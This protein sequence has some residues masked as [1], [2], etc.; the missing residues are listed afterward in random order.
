MSVTT[1]SKDDFSKG[2]TL[3]AKRSKDRNYSVAH[4]LGHPASSRSLTRSATMLS[5]QN[6]KKPI[7]EQVLKIARKM[8]DPKA[9]NL[10]YLLEDAKVLHQKL[11]ALSMEE[12]DLKKV[13]LFSNEHL[14][15]MEAS[16]KKAKE[17]SAY[18]ERLI[19]AKTLTNVSPSLR[20]SV[21]GLNSSQHTISKTLCQSTISLDSAKKSRSLKRSLINA[22]GR[23][24]SQKNTS[25][26]STKHGNKKRQSLGSVNSSGRRTTTATVISLS[27]PNSPK[28][29]HASTMNRSSSCDA[30]STDCDE[31]SN[32]DHPAAIF[33]KGPDP[34]AAILNNKGASMR[35]TQSHTSLQNDVGPLRILRGSTSPSPSPP[36]SI[37]FPIAR[38]RS[39]DVP[40]AMRSL[41]EARETTSVPTSPTRGSR[42]V[43]RSTRSQLNMERTSSAT[44]SNSP[45]PEMSFP[46]GQQKKPPATAP[47]PKYK[48]LSVSSAEH[49]STLPSPRRG[50][51]A[52][53]SLAVV[54]DSRSQSLSRGYCIPRFSRQSSDHT[55]H[56]SQE[57]TG[58]T[59]HL[60]QQQGSNNSPHKS[61]RD[62]YVS[63]QDSDC[64][65]QTS[66]DYAEHTP[67]V[68]SHTPRISH[69]GTGHTSRRPGQDSDHSPRT[70]QEG[71]NKTTGL[72]QV[73]SNRSHGT[74]QQHF[75]HSPPISEQPLN[76]T[77]PQPRI[78]ERPSDHTSPRTAQ[79]ASKVIPHTPMR[80]PWA[81]SVQQG[82]NT[83]STFNSKQSV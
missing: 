45:S 13:G 57:S 29:K 6:H 59:P 49:S 5:S 14:V 8:S 75:N 28:R 35:S 31:P 71:A 42:S 66:Q 37:S 39:A 11:M 70:S 16:A 81:G 56:S 77:P 74:S 4:M 15:A 78:S 52:T 61:Q 64:T 21:T 58:H 40:R 7:T 38:Q 30:L 80:D 9:L 68:S 65:P 1:C 55:P 46:K 2:S 73:D 53:Q 32:L 23:S 24:K 17:A 20:S 60:S 36:P 22:F 48:S 50:L 54:G 62:T 10:A 83:H 12:V 34:P 51:R 47:K 72:S 69:D 18:E 82:H 25:E 63:R 19:R 33:N 41:Y 43:A 67:H 26:Y 44:S 76:H 79:A 3:P 27:R